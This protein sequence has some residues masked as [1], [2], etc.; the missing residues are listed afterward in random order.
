MARFRATLEDGDLLPSRQNLKEDIPGRFAVLEAA[1]IKNLQDLIGALK[2]KKRLEEFH[3]QTALPLDYL[4]VL[5]REANSY[6]PKPVP[7][8]KFPGVDQGVVKRLEALGI[9]H[10]KHLFEQAGSSIARADMVRQAAISAGDLL[11]LVQTRIVGVG[12]IFARIFLD[13]GIKD[14]D[15]LAA[16]SPQPLFERLLAVNTEKGYTKVMATIKDVR[17]CIQMAKELP[18]VIEY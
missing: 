17:W 11:E 14:L 12:P 16:T 8:D 5:R 13:A 2:T 18:R 10:S 3:Q 4:K 15:S 6:L 9:K 7:L 1:G